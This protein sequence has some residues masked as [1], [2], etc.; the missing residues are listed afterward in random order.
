MN[1]SSQK[2][3][4]LNQP[5]PQ[6]IDQSPN[7]P[8]TLNNFV[9]FKVGERIGEPQRTKSVDAFFDHRMSISIGYTEY[10][11]FDRNPMVFETTNTFHPAQSD[12]EPHPVNPSSKKN[13]F[14]EPYSTRQKSSYC[15]KLRVDDG[16]T[17]WVKDIKGR[18][19]LVCDLL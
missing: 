14:I 12:P 19:T 13:H 15:S 11:S 17:G 9:L 8:K 1:P 3:Q 10:T 2:S 18:Y 4:L 6:T 16:F 5:N 7:H